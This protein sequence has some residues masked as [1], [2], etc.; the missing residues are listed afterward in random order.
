M[1][2]KFSNNGSALLA[3]DLIIGQ[4]LIVVQAGYGGRF[5]TTDT[6]DEYFL[7]VL[8]DGV[9]NREIVR[10]TLR[11]GDSL[12]V[13]RA[14][15]ATTERD[16]PAGARIGVR[17]TA[18]T[19]GRFIEPD[20]AQF[21]GDVDLNANALTNG[22]IVAVPVRGESADVSNQLVVP[23]AGARPYSSGN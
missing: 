2:Q 12:V 17:M 18:G 3:Q 10:C 1:P 16:F 15:E 20:T 13:V 6:D 7:A 5:P 4:T 9:G 19:M 22:E 11:S 14:W 23:P 8:D 21:L